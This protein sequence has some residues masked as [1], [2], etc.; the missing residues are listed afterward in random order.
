MRNRKLVSIAD[1]RK[2]ASISSY[3]RVFAVI[4]VFNRLHFTR[5]CINYLKAQTYPSITIIV[6]DGGSTDGTVETI[7]S[8]HPDVIVLTSD[9]EL[10]WSGSMAMG[11]EYVL[12]K[13]ER[14]DDFVLMM[15]NDTVIPQDY[16][17]NLV[18]ASQCQNAAVGALIVDSCNPDI[19]LDAG[20]YIDWTTY[21]FPVK[22]TVSSGELFCSDVDFLPGRGSLVPLRM[23][24]KAGN[25]DAALLPHYLADYEFFYRLKSKGFR[26]G[27]CYG[28][29]VLAHIGETGLCHGNGPISLFTLWKE[30]FA[31]RSM[32]NV[33]DH[34]R[35]IERHAPDRFRFACKKS[36]IKFVLH[37]IAHRTILRF[38]LLPLIFTWRIIQG[39]RRSFALFLIP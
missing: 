15:N 35:F 3:P 9:K 18:F 33:V 26:L 14:P 16:V 36:M 5:E 21:S 23:I 27:V 30:L 28:T 39:Q 12:Q 2:T 19:I 11:I 24:H 37:N 7:R 34:W 29:K 25:V 6:A 17:S 1:N 38:P 13:S 22:T 31:R 20:E 32:S 8:E 4:P 10:W